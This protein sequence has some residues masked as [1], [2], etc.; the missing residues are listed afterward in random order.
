[1]L[2]DQ[3]RAVYDN[4]ILKIELPLAEPQPGVARKV[5][6]EVPEGNADGENPGG[7]AIEDGGR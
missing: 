5:P 2:G 4:G 3:A 7:D 1:V 6:I